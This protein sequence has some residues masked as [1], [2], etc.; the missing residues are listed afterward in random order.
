MTGALVQGQ[1]TTLSGNQ[2]NR[3]IDMSSK[4]L[5]LEPDSAP[6]TQI[7]KNIRKASTVNP[8]FQWQEDE[9]D[10]RYDR[11]NNGGG[12]TS[13]ATLLTVDN[14]A[15]FEP[16]QVVSVTRTNE[17]ML[18]TAVDTTNNRLTV[19]RG[20][21]GFSAA[22]VDNDELMAANTAHPE[23]DTPPEARNR[24]PVTQFNYAQIFRNTVSMSN[25][26]INS[27]YEED[28]DWKFQT[29]KKG[30]EHRSSIE[31]AFMVG[32]P[33]ELTG[34]S[35]VRRF[36]GGFKHFV[37]SNVTDAGGTF[38]EME[39]FTALRPM[40][41]YGRKEKWGLCAALVVDVLNGFPRGKL[42]MRQN[43]STFGLRITQYISPH[44][45]LNVATHWLLEGD[46]LGGEMWV[47][48]TETIRYR[49]MQSGAGGE[50]DTHINQHVEARGTDGRQDEWLT[51]CGMEF[52]LEKRHGRVYN[53]TG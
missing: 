3:S 10:P 53:I 40:F 7:T 28:N 42:E 45:T 30:I 38:T 27:G 5:L 34:G 46:T 35:G 47:L 6:L 19:T 16:N 4:I 9:L 13:A 15:Y 11:I 44:G 33:A 49:Y 23:G 14:A 8:K 36:T 2:D 31:R 43:D 18:V 32:R 52:G 50:R 21:G 51:E 37:S 29:L 39:F 12:Y 26:A 25:T 20:I 1:R 17:S 41:R 48:D 24:N 22:L